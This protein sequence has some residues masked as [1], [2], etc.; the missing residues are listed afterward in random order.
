LTNK[1]IYNN[2]TAGSDVISNPHAYNNINGLSMAS[3]VSKGALSVY[4]LENSTNTIN[5]TSDTFIVSSMADALI[6]TELF[7]FM[8][9]SMTYV[10]VLDRRNSDK[11]I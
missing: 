1:T 3:Y 6:L 2:Y 11:T 10:S 9:M 7:I 4:D 8:D 5:K